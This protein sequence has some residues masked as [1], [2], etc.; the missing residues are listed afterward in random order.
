MG[1]WDWIPSGPVEPVLQRFDCLLRFFLHGQAEAAGD[2]RHVG[3]AGVFRAGVHP[4]TGRVI[5][6]MLVNVRGGRLGLADSGQTVKGDDPGCLRLLVQFLED[7][8]DVE[9]VLVPDRDLPEF[10]GLRC[11][12]GGSR[13]PAQVGVDPVELVMGYGVSALALIAMSLK[14]G[15]QE[16]RLFRLPLESVVFEQGGFA[17]EQPLDQR[18]T[19]RSLRSP[20]ISPHDGRG[21]L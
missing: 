12:G 15:D 4:E 16:S 18:S 17:R 2:R 8:V 19:K 21:R 3:R 6:A 11:A 10:R 9:K 14:R 5:G 20:S 7:A 1:A 13:Q